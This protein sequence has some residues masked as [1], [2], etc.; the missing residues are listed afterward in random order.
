M[1]ETMEEDNDDLVSIIYCD[2][3][4]IENINRNVD[5]S[6]NVSNKVYLRNMERAVRDWKKCFACEQKIVQKPY[7]MGLFG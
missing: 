4:E 7:Y 5:S 2:E 3:E 1:G 6:N